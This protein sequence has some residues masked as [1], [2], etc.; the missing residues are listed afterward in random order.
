VLAEVPDY[1]A[2]R[3]VEETIVEVRSILS[4]APPAV[5]PP[6]AESTVSDGEP[7]AD[8]PDADTREWHNT[9]PRG[10][11]LKRFIHQVLTIC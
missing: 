2:L 10:R 1:R 7:V 4:E 8:V 11:L 3:A 5:Q 9:R 6:V